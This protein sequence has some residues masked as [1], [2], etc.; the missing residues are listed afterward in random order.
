MS[1]ITGI[2][3]KS[4]TTYE[5]RPP[6]AGA[7]ASGGDPVLV[8]RPGGVAGGNVYVDVPTL[9]AAAK[10]VQG[11]KTIF[12]DLS[13]APGDNNAH[14]PAGTWDFG[15][16]VTWQGD[17]S[18][19]LN[20]PL[21]LVFD[22]GAMV[23][24]PTIFDMANAF[25]T[26]EDLNVISNSVG[27]V[28]IYAGKGQLPVTLQGVARLAAPGGA[29]FFS[30]TDPAAIFDVSLYGQSKL[31]KSGA[32]FVAQ[33]G[34]YQLFDTSTIEP[35]TVNH[36]SSTTFILAP[37]AS[38]SP[39]Q[40]GVVPAFE[41]APVTHLTSSNSGAAV[42]VVVPGAEA[43]VGAV[44]ALTRGTDTSGLLTIKAGAG[45]L[46]GDLVLVTYAIPYPPGVI[47]NVVIGR[48]DVGTGAGEFGVGA[49]T[50]TG[51]SISTIGAVNPTPGNTYAFTYIAIP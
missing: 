40:L 18:V 43:G 45:A 4:P 27:A 34:T 48:N 38:A 9:A 6:G 23:A 15:L 26:F 32:V 14:I 25:T 22:N 3:G 11:P 36:T 35:N 19:A 28:Y 44:A 49:M 1:S 41:G 24:T 10:A 5:T 2:K 42:P 16:Y 21:G 47:P 29:L 12:V 51:F 7:A 30:A 31:A 8:F 39:S 33:A 37:G 20:S 17:P 46:V 13:L 50:N